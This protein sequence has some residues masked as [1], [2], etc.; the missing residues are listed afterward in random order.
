MT[1]QISCLMHTP[2]EHITELA[3]NNLCNNN[4]TTTSSEANRPTLPKIPLT[5]RWKE[6][7]A[8]SIEHLNF[9]DRVIKTPRQRISSS[10]NDLNKQT[11]QVGLQIG[12]GQYA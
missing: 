6:R 4:W 1:V 8:L 10:G 9:L 5:A 7:L 11:K 2:P 3:Y 12:L